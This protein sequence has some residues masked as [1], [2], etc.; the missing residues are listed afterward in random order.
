MHGVVDG[1][2]APSGLLLE[3]LLGVLGVV[4][5][6][7]GAVAQLED[8]FVDEVAVVG[9]LVIAHEGQGLVPGIDTEPERGAHMRHPADRDLGR[10]HRDGVVGDA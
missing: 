5:D 7:V 9:R 2:V 3:L 1:G 10:A 4:D 6:E 8:G